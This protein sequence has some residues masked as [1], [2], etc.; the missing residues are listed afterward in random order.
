MG[1]F[2]LWKVIIMDFKNELE[3]R[4]QLPVEKRLQYLEESVQDIEKLLDEFR[5]VIQLLNTGT[6]K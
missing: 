5:K 2:L 3:L 4:K 1:G 6:N